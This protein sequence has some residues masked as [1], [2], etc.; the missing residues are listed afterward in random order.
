MLSSRNGG[1]PPKMRMSHLLK[2]TGQ[3]CEAKNGRKD[4]MKKLQKKWKMKHRNE[5]K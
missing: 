1:K 2:K 3:N 4:E 5:G